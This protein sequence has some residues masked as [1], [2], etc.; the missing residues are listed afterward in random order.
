VVD[1][2]LRVL[3]RA[4]LEGLTIAA[5]AEELGVSNATPYSYFDS[6]D[7]LLNAIADQVIGSVPE[8]TAGPGLA[9]AREFARS[10]HRALLGH[11]AVPR[12]L[13]D[14]TVTGPGAAR[15]QEILL[16]ALADA[17]LHDAECVVAYRVLLSYLTG[18]TQRR[19]AFETDPARESD[20]HRAL[21]ELSRDRFPTLRRMLPLLDVRMS[22][23]EFDLG[24]DQLLSRYAQPTRG[25]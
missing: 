7:A 3:D 20:R 24:L 15:S 16:T 17:G 22:D 4:G 6:K 14:R 12:M 5:V 1:A 18:F 13:A 25:A 10:L 9:R 19:I 23:A 11:P 21:E 8:P 2:G